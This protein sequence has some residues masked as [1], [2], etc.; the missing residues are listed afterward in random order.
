MRRLFSSK[1]TTL[2]EEKSAM[3][4]PLLVLGITPSSVKL[5][6]HLSQTLNQY[7]PNE[8]EFFADYTSFLDTN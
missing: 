5:A 7:D 2:Y 6:K 1:S 4:I 8:I 3:H